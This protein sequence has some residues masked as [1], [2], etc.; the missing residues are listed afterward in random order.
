MTSVEQKRYDDQYQSRRDMIFNR[1]YYKEN[2]GWADPSGK[3]APWFKVM[4]VIA[5][6]E[7]W[8]V[9]VHAWKKQEYAGKKP[10]PVSRVFEMPN[11]PLSLHVDTVIQEFL[12]SKDVESHMNN[13]RTNKKERCSLVASVEVGK[14]VP[15]KEKGFWARLF[16]S[17]KSIFK[18]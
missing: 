9:V 13:S 8:K 11:T 10:A 1:V 16:E 12:Q 4:S 7:G 17:I 2:V 15:E 5:T 14:P 6:E 3:D 18:K